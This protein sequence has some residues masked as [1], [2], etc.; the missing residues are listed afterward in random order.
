MR[1]SMQS[2][3]QH[4]Q[5][6]DPCRPAYTLRTAASASAHQ[7]Q[8]GSTWWRSGS[9]QSRSPKRMQTGLPYTHQ[10]CQ[11]LAHTA[12]GV[13]AVC[14]QLLTPRARASQPAAAALATTGAPVGAGYQ[15]RRAARAPRVGWPASTHTRSPAVRARSGR[16]ACRMRRVASG[17]QGRRAL[18][19]DCAACRGAPAWPE[20][21]G[22]PAPRLC[23]GAT[24]RQALG[25][26]RGACCQLKGSPGCEAPS[27]H[28][29][30][31]WPPT[32]QAGASARPPRSWSVKGCFASLVR[33]SRLVISVLCLAPTTVLL[34]CLSKDGSIRTT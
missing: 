16:R 21:S 31:K 23:S 10:S 9:S 29:P 33:S 20:R 17:P 7:R 14:P 11:I 8:L 34:V 27:A 15:T 30:A 2:T 5:T 32:H 6:L 26:S 4:R 28:A 1:S 24:L 13:R 18:A 19:V 12:A 3:Q 22:G 25:L